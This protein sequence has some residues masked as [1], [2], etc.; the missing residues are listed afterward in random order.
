MNR[1]MKFTNVR[2][3][4]GVNSIEAPIKFVHNK[5]YDNV[6]ILVFKKNMEN[7]SHIVYCDIKISYGT[8]EKKFGLKKRDLYYI[9]TP[10]QTLNCG[11]V[12]E[13]LVNSDYIKNII[14]GRE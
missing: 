13:M 10:M 8:L 9:G 6:T 3:D 1:Y 5:N 14:I 7:G 4:I 12:K 11:E 2:I